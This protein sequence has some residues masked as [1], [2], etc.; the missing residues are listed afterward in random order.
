MREKEEN[1]NTQQKVP[2]I[3]TIFTNP[4]RTL[5]AGSEY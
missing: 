1:D 4:E 3:Y 2:L 5:D